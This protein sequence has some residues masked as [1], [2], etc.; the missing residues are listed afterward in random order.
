[1]ARSWDDD[2][3]SASVYGLDGLV[4]TRYSLRIYTVV[5]VSHEEITAFTE[6]GRGPDRLFAAVVISC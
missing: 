3:N 2:P 4:I 6:R 1:M 5:H